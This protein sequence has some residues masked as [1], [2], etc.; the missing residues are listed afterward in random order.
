[1]Q[2]IVPI[3]SRSP[4]APHLPPGASNLWLRLQTDPCAHLL[5]TWAVL[6][7][8]GFSAQTSQLVFLCR[9]PLCLFLASIYLTFSVERLSS[10]ALGGMLGN[11]EVLGPAPMKL[12]AN[13]WKTR[14]S[15]LL[16]QGRFCILRAQRKVSP[17]LSLSCRQ[18]P[19]AGC[20][21]RSATSRLEDTLGRQ[22][23]GWIRRQ[24]ILR[25]RSNG[26]WRSNGRG[27]DG[28]GGV[29]HN[30]QKWGIF[31]MPLTQPD[32]LVVRVEYRSQAWAWP[33]LTTK[34]HQEVALNRQWGSC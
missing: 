23:G 14:Q 34:F 17:G 3:L 33:F 4:K 20:Q 29:A 11:R 26:R 6:T 18:R 13:Y 2:H 5:G 12:L 21:Q 9:S 7:G 28:G 8:Q 31:E 15:R 16:G 22:C 30:E 27:G 1:M 32:W 10:Q 25:Q 24:E 19:A